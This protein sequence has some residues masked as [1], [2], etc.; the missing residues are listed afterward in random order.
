VGDQVEFLDGDARHLAP[1]AGPA[2]LLLSNILR[3][4]N[5]ALLPSIVSA[6]RPGG[7]A[8]FSGMEEQ[9]APLFRPPL[10]SAGFEPLDEVVD[11]GWWAVAARR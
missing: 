1:L 2:D 11:A 8:I 9:E 4:V 10:A 7:I 5:T 3:G 6:L